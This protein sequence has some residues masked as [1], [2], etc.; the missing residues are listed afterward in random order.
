[1]SLIIVY[2]HGYG[3]SPKSDKVSVLR[4]ALGV[5]VFAFP[6]NIDPDIACREIEFNIDMMLLDNMHARDQVLFVGTSLGGWMAS[7]MASK[8]RVPAIIIN[9]S[10]TPKSSL[11]KYGVSQ[12][13]CDKYEDLTIS[14]HN[15]YFVAENDEV[16]DSSVLRRM[17]S[18]APESVELYIDS[19]ADHRF[20]GAPFDRVVKYIEKTF[21]NQ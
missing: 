14:P 12:E 15:T 4:E 18:M 5:P 1:M 11:V 20:N 21:K 17:V 9:P 10:V 16:I 19:D 13:I 3:S 7:K 8:Y 6:A 2:F